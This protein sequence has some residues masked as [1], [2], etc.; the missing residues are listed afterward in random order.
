MSFQIEPEQ[1]AVSSGS[2]RQAEERAHGNLPARVG[3]ADVSKR[4][5]DSEPGLWPPRPSEVGRDMV[6]APTNDMPGQRRPECDPFRELDSGAVLRDPWGRTF[7]LLNGGE[8]YIRASR[9]CRQAGAASA[10]RAERCDR[11]VSGVRIIGRDCRID[12]AR[13]RSWLHGYAGRGHEGSIVGERMG[14]RARPEPHHADQCDHLASGVCVSRV[15]E[16]VGRPAAARLRLSTLPAPQ[17][18]ATRP[19]HPTPLN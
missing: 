17:A 11:A 3:R 7:G 15:E 18:L 16:M 13:E 6:A 19:T 10:P 4:T 1:H 2:N 14:E 8:A 12:P 5:A 9:S